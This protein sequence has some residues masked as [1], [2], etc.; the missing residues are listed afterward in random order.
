MYNYTIASKR[1]MFR[2][3][4][5]GLCLFHHLQL[6][7]L[8]HHWKLKPTYPDVPQKKGPC[9][10]RQ[11]IIIQNCYE[12]M[13]NNC[14]W[15]FHTVWEL[16]DDDGNYR[17]GDYTVYWVH[18]NMK[19]WRVFSGYWVTSQGWLKLSIKKLGIISA[20]NMRLECLPGEHLGGLLV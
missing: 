14:R 3:I 8:C 4:H 16:L 18:R 19:I 10:W 9:G 6:K 7:P 15:I 11:E 17:V 5:E 1:T 13:K 12:R 20:S 2:P